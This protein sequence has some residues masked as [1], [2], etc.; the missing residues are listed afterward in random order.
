[1]VAMDQYQ[2]EVDEHPDSS[3]F[4]MFTKGTHG[5]PLPCQPRSDQNRDRL[6]L[7]TSEK[8]S[9]AINDDAWKLFFKN[10]SSYQ[11]ITSNKSWWIACGPTP[12]RL[13]ESPLPQA[14]SDSHGSGSSATPNGTLDVAKPQLQRWTSLRDPSLID[15]V[16]SWSRTGSLAPETG[17]WFQGHWLVVTRFRNG[18][19]KHWHL[20]NHY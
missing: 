15:P 14:L 10:R 12:K 19:D 7:W 3:T 11:A 4:G 2:N 13:I 16:V 17:R 8:C 1:M 9:S 20:I 18:F 5:Y 6:Q